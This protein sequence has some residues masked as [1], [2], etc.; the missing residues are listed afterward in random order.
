MK[1][2]KTIKYLEEL[3][4]LG[5]NYGLERTER[6]LELLG[7]PH[8][9][10]KLIHIAGTN[11]KGST[12]SILGKVLIEHGYKVGFF[13]SP[14]LEEIEETIRV[15]DENIL[16]EDLVYLLEEI[17]PYVNKVVEEGYKHPTE[18]EVLTCI[19]FLYLYRQKVDF[20]VIEVGLGGR[21]DSTNVIKPIL[22]IITSISLDHT[23]ILGNTIEEITNEKVGII[24]E[25]IPVITCN[26]KNEAIDI[27]KDKALLTKSK[28][29]IVDS[30]D[31]VFLEIVNDDIPY[32]RVSVNFNNNKYTLDLALLG[33]HQIINLSLAIKALEELEK[34][35][36]IKVNINKLYK[37]VKNVKWKGRLEVLKK[38]PF[39]VIDG[40][41]NIAG[42]EFL[43]SNIEEYFKYKN[44]Y[45]ILG[46]LADKNVEEMVKII[47][48]VA[49]EVYTVTANSIRAA[50][51]NE[52]KEVVLE[53][54][55]NCIAFDDYDKA[56]KL[57][58]SKAN[59]DDLIVAAGS[60]YMI[61]E[62]RKQINNI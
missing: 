58:L 61:G 1:D 18:F 38:D 51:A 14:H 62:I 3:R 43:K 56:I 40:A 22:S 37:G 17:K 39:I 36:Y 54:N 32:Q 59:K 53:Y 30:N 35:N 57:S 15:N 24:K 52:L 28:L 23:N 19:M 34:L 46:I 12:S 55:N 11:G 4:V 25:S 41:H 13:N 27:I 31:F 7:N 20:G 10:L 26:Q 50:S 60:L 29:T 21:L 48:P 45:L 2:L 8:K 47:A 33:K 42:I 6:L 5:S 49:T 44:L 16:E 9:K